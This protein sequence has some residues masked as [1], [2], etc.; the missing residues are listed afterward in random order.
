MAKAYP[1]LTSLSLEERFKADFNIPRPKA[2]MT[3]SSHECISLIVACLSRYK[4]RFLEKNKNISFPIQSALV[5][6][7]LK[8]LPSDV[9]SGRKALALVMLG[10]SCNKLKQYND[11]YCAF[12]EAL[13]VCLVLRCLESRKQIAKDLFHDALA[14]LVKCWRSSEPISMD[15]NVS[16][17]DIEQIMN[18]IIIHFYS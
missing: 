7:I 4:N 6:V 16:T 3:R 15:G 9:N 14:G 11:A 5:D 2:F 18:F 1:V 12:Y 17:D 8:E 13:E 10:E